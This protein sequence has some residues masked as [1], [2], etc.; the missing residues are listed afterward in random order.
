MLLADLGA[1]V[2]K[3]ESLKGGDPSRE[4]KP[5][6]GDL[7]H[8]FMSVNRGKKSFSMDLRHAGAKAVL[9]GLIS[10]GDILIENFRPGVM[11]KMGFDYEA[12]KQSNPRIIYLSIS[13]F[14]QTG[15]Y[16]HKPAY[17]MVAQGVGGTISITGTADSVPVRVGYSI[18]DMGAGLFGVVASLA[19][20]YEREHSGKGQHI[21]LAMMDSQVALCE[22]AF[23][24]YFV[25]N[26]VPKPLGTRHP[27]V[28][29]FQ[30]FET[31]TDYMVV[32]ANREYEWKRLCKTIGREDLLK[33]ERFLTNDLRTENHNLL[34]KEFNE[35][36]RKKPRDEWLALFDREGVVASP[37]NT[38]EQVANDSHAQA[39]D[40][41]VNIAHPRLGA[42]KVV[43]TPMKFSRTPCEI[44]NAPPDLGEHTKEI[45]RDDLNLSP[46][47]IQVLQDEALI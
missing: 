43:G 24:R 38:I 1:E 28:T 39:R 13:G 20:L 11:K 33:D 36:F 16:A 6:V 44:T 7:S 27:I 45:L 25:S 47:D 34:E 19:A 37:V 17:D 15:P 18:G 31:Q 2:I 21:D 12:A 29:P 35:Y 14:G 4:N 8:Y 23:S 40:M 30:V 9:D 32:I 41:F 10:Q 3:I 42:L 22:N 26:E 46:E 5:L